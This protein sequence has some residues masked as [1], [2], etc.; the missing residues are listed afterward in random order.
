MTEHRNWKTHLILHF[1][2]CKKKPTEIVNDLEEIGFVSSLGTVD[3]TYTWD[4]VPEKEDVLQMADRV[5]EVLEG[6]GAIFNLDTHD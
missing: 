3:L 6:T 4:K 5:A 1:G 2:S